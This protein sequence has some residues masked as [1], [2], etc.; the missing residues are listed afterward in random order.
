MPTRATLTNERKHEEFDGAMG[1]THKSNKEGETI[2]KTVKRR[3]S[4][5]ARRSKGTVDSEV[6]RSPGKEVCWWLRNQA[7]LQLPYLTTKPASRYTFSSPLSHIPNEPLH[8]SCLL[9]FST[10]PAP[11]PAFVTS[12]SPP[13]DCKHGPQARLC[14]R[15][16]LYTKPIGICRL[17]H[18]TQNHSTTGS[19]TIWVPIVYRWNHRIF[20]LV[21]MRSIL[22][23]S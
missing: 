18:T 7:K 15:P 10:V 3:K 6:T 11:L 8:S 5:L 16:L 20:L 23:G 14:D 12:G 1:I 21:Y 19:P 2:E 9:T 13:I 22:I 17:W 4:R